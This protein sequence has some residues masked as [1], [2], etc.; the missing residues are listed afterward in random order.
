MCM[1]KRRKNECA[2]TI[3]IGVWFEINVVLSHFPLS[4]RLPGNTGKTIVGRNM[5]NPR[6]MVLAGCC[7]MLVLLRHLGLNQHADFIH[8]A[9]IKIVKQNKVSF[10]LFLKCFL[11]PV[12]LNKLFLMLFGNFALHTDPAIFLITYTTHVILKCAI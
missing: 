9:V 5:A 8:S 12:A 4:S 6:A 3:R 2:Q 11:L 7:W 10:I 1:K